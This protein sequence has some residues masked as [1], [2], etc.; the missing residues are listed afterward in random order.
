M[1]QVVTPFRQRFGSHIR[2][3]QLNVRQF[4]NETY[5]GHCTGRG[6]ETTPSPMSWSPR[7]LDL[8]TLYSS[9]WGITKDKAAVLHN[10]INAKLRA[11]ITNAF[12]PFNTINITEKLTKDFATHQ[13][14]RLA[15]RCP[16]RSAG[17]IKCKYCEI[18]KDVRGTVTCRTFCI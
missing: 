2:A 14:L 8:T 9:L 4:L 17:F 6:S 1:N 11:T 15:S 5:P 10:N 3:E 16:H 7:S 18:N 13:A 12:A